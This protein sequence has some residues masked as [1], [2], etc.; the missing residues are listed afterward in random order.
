VISICDFNFPFR[1]LIS[2]YVKL[3]SEKLAFCKSNIIDYKDVE[4]LRQGDETKNKIGV[5]QDMK[6]TESFFRSNDIVL[7]KYDFIF[8][9]NKNKER[10]EMNTN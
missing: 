4:H 8:Y 2:V 3:S 7:Q 10:N 9:V 6:L 1:A 5:S